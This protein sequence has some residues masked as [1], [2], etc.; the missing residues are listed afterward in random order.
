MQYL[1]RKYDLLVDERTAEQIKM[2]MAQLHLLQPLTMKSRPQPR[3]GVPRTGAIDDS[4]IRESP[5]NVCR[6]HCEPGASLERTHSGLS[7]DISDR[8]IVLTAAARCSKISTSAP[9][10]NRLAGLHRRRS[11]LPWCSAPE[12]CSA[13]STVA[14]DVHRLIACAGCSP[15]S[16][17]S[18]RAERD[19]L[20]LFA[21]WECAQVVASLVLL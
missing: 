7:A 15:S 8:G 18:S 10:R 3:R 4:E 17:M 14:P 16:G 9:R 6:H 20:L 11:W 1:K 12:K 19:L 21:V 5:A 13:T 2:E